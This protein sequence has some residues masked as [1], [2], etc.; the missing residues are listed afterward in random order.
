MID[1]YCPAHKAEVSLQTEYQKLFLANCEEYARNKDWRQLHPGTPNAL[2][3]PAPVHFAWMGASS[4]DAF[5]LS[6]TEDF[7]RIIAR[8]D[9]CTECDVYNLEVDRTYYW[10]V[11]DSEIRSFHTAYELPR[12]I[13]AEGTDNVRDIGGY[14]TVYG[15]RVKQGMIYRGAELNVHNFL[16]KKGRQRLVEDLGIRCDYDFR[17]IEE[18]WNV[19]SSPLGEDI[20]YLRTPRNRADAFTFFLETHAHGP[21]VLRF[22]LQNKDLYPIYFHG[23]EGIQRTD[24]VEMFLLAI[25]GVSDEDL[26][27]I[28]EASSLKGPISVSR[29][30]EEAHEVAF[31]QTMNAHFYGNTIHES[32]CTFLRMIG[33][34]DAELDE[35]RE[36]MLEPID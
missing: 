26:M 11:G 27:R 20:H 24:T 14:N 16:T 31:Y 35:F 18:D 25:L 22:F 12:F 7:A 17:L 3:A 15:R 4:D 34:T 5:L 21:F 13:L 32:I 30:G 2:T 33:V 1:L 23:S 8:F 6:D 19:K 28:H 36:M 10:R 9:H 29:H